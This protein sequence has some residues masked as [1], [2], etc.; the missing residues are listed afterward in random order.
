MKYRDIAGKEVGTIEEV[1]DSYHATAETILQLLPDGWRLSSYSP[2]L[3]FAPPQTSGP[4][5]RTL[6]LSA[7]LAC[8]MSAKIKALLHP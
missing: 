3:T 2:G 1:S 4:D 8:E 6:Q 7:S 5:N